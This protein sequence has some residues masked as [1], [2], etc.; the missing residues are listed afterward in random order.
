MRKLAIELI[1][2]FLVLAGCASAE[3]HVVVQ[4][5]KA[6][7]VET[8]DVKAGDTVNFQNSDSVVHNVFS[9]DAANQFEIKAQLPGQETAVQFET[10]GTT[11]VRCAIHPGMK[12]QVNVSKR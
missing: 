4:K 2:S 7:S 8:L 12:L 3:E 6:F 11:E 9:R 5:D 1:L 10:P